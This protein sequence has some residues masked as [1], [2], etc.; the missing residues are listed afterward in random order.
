M[1]RAPVALV[2]ALAVMLTLGAPASWADPAPAA[3]TVTPATASTP[4]PD[5]PGDDHLPIPPA[6]LADMQARA[7]AYQAELGG[8]AGLRT[9]GS[10][11][12]NGTGGTSSTPGATTN[13]AAA[14]A[15]TPSGMPFVGSATLWCTYSNPGSPGNYCS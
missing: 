9:N 10:D 4:P 11:G 7:R 1:R 3:G 15:T 14:A 5:G 12:A 13:D 2:A 8:G 6:E